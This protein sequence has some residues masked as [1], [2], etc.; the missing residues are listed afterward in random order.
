M[1]MEFDE[2]GGENG[3]PAAAEEIS[4]AE[5][6]TETLKAPAKNKG[7]DKDLILPE[8]SPIGRFQ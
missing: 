8:S 2:D 1:K 6:L 5:R 3:E 7:E 4:L